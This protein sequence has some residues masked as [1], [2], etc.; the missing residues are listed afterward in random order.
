[1]TLQRVDA[2]EWTGDITLGSLAPAIPAADVVEVAESEKA[3]VVR[4]ATLLEKISQQLEVIDARRTQLLDEL[5]QV[6]IELAV[7]AASHL[8]FCAIQADQFGIEDLIA[9]AIGQIDQSLETTIVLH[10]DDSA[11]L[12]KRSHDAVEKWSDQ[13]ASLITDDSL[14]RGA[15]DIR[16]PGSGHLVT[17]IGT[18]LSEIRRH[19]MEELDDTQ[20]ERRETQHH[21]KQ[22]RRFP[23][24]QGDCLASGKP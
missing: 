22:L 7:S 5:R 6:A 12:H 3:E 18:R 19:W 15:C 23:G 2:Q 8:A 9:T 14:A 11:L 1:M 16:Q 4:V 21:G 20:V 10:P 13:R 17:D 24:P